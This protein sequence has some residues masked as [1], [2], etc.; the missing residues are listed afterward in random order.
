MKHSAGMLL[1][2]LLCVSLA[3]CSQRSLP[4]QA[5]DGSPWS[6]GWTTVGNVVGVDVPEYV[7]PR[8]NSDALSSRDMYYATWSVGEGTP[9]VNADGDDATA[10]DAQFYLLL[11]GYDSAEK[12]EEALA[13]WQSLA[14]SQYD[15]TETTEVVCNGQAFTV[16]TCTYR[17]ETTPYQQGASAFGIYRNYAISVELS[18]LDSS[19]GGAQ[20]MLIDFLERCHYAA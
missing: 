11:A 19:G 2:V 12:A 18:C 5:A 8:E 13:D 4:E 20:P 6:G 16:I 9:Y 14:A 15:V 7:T 10:Y 17:S 1:I 3:G